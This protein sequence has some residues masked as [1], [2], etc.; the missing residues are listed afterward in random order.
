MDV[1][2]KTKAVILGDISG[3]VV[4]VVYVVCMN[5]AIKLWVTYILLCIGSMGLER[6]M[7][8]LRESLTRM[9]TDIVLQGGCFALVVWD[10]WVFHQ[11]KGVFCNKIDDNI[12]NWIATVSTN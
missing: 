3:V 12:R 2:P 5:S 4:F 9:A 11:Q 1:T 7:Q 8:R 6:R 10:A